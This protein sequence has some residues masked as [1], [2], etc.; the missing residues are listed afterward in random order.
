M[1]SLQDMSKIRL[2]LYA[3]LIMNN[4]PMN[5]YIFAFIFCT[6][7]LS[8]FSQKSELSGYVVDKKSGEAIIGA[9]T[10]ELATHIGTSTNKFGYFTLKLNKK[11]ILTLQFSFTGYD[12]KTISVHLNSDT[13]LN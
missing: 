11:E 13:I 2:I 12:S 8:V 10:L 3:K 1:E 6:T 5:K 9:N 4:E 7:T